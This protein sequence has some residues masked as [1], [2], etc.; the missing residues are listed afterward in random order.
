MTIDG[1]AEPENHS[2]SYTPEDE[3]QFVLEDNT[4]MEDRP[5]SDV[6]VTI[7]EASPVSTEEDISA[8]ANRQ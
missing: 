6:V 7:R 1:A 8:D 3:L 5:R 2:V 4:K